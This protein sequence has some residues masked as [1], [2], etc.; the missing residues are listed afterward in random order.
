[1]VKGIIFTILSAIIY[2][3]MPVF[4]H[5]VYD[6]GANA[7][8]LTFYRS[9]L[10]LPVLFVLMMQQKISFLLTIEEIKNIIIIGLF[11]SVT[12][13]LLLY[14]SY[15]YINSGM[16]TTLHFLYPMFTI[17]LSKFFYHDT[18]D[19]K[20]WLS[21]IIATAGILC[22]LN[23]NNGSNIIGI[24]MALA[25][26]ITFAM[27]LIGI[28][29]R[30]LAVMNGYKL[31]FYLALVVVG[32]LLIM[33]VFTKS[34]IFILPIKAYAYLMII[35]QSASFLGI[36]L[37]KEGIR[38]IGSKLASLFSLFEPLSSIVVGYAFLKE[39]IGWVQLVGCSLILYSVFLLAKGIKKA[40]NETH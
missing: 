38:L 34:I 18:I 27:Y 9:L 37:L 19:K 7:I 29:K 2:G 4:C 40:S 28:E 31:S 22:F 15:N 36:I 1:M 13:T 23:S 26:S 20:Q 24:T 25:S 21:L 10:V 5:Q 12:T 3:V 30:K 32:S 6:L 8:T 17:I 33:N 35:A 39:S 11:G 16:A 14:A